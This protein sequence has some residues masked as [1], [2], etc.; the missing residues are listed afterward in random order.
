MKDSCRI[1]ASE[2]FLMHRWPCS[3]LEDFY[4]AYYAVSCGSF[5]WHSQM[6]WNDIELHGGCSLKYDIFCHNEAFKDG[7]NITIKLIKKWKR[8]T[9]YILS[10]VTG[11]KKYNF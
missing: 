6:Q 4:S 10:N 9:E 5:F 2:M 8:D 7:N 11:E 3:P 1:R